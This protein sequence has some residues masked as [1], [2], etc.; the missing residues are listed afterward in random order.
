MPV[1]AFQL[2][3]PDGILGPSKLLELAGDGLTF[4]VAMRLLAERQSCDRVEVWSGDRPVAAYHR[5]QPI[6]RP[7]AVPAPSSRHTMAG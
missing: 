5:E 1:Y 6:I 4:A 3:N 7:V 2:S